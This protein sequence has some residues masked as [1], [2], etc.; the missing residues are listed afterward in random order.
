MH[1]LHNLPE[2]IPIKHT[3]QRLSRQE[4]RQNRISNH[5]QHIQKYIRST[6]EITV[7]RLCNCT[8]IYLKGHMNIFHHTSASAQIYQSQISLMKENTTNPCYLYTIHDSVTYHWTCWHW[9]SKQLHFKTSL[10]YSIP[11]V[12][13]C[14]NEQS[15]YELIAAKSLPQ[16]Q[17][18]LKNNIDACNHRSPP[19]AQSEQPPKFLGW[20][21]I[22]GC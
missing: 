12:W 13:Q 14:K 21:A 16:L 6:C 5:L 7:T 22:K 10:H 17:P 2:S 19:Q 8:A 4:R 15:I 3:T 20:H 9:V 18:F 1:I 11:K